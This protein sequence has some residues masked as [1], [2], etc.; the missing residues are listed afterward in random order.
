VPPRILLRVVD[1]GDDVD[2]G[3]GIVQ[4]LDQLQRLRLRAR[5]EI[6]AWI[7]VCRSAM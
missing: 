3:A 1:Q 2:V 5:P 4:Q 6:T 7:G